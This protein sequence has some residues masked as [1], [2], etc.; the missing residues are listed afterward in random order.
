MF[1]PQ[2][3][4]YKTQYEQCNTTQYNTLTIPALL[5]GSQD[6]TVKARDSREI[7]AADMKFM[8]K[9]AGYTWTDY[10]TNTKLVKELNI[11]TILYKIQEYNRNWV[12]YVKS[13]VIDYL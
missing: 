11:T 10:K 7:T 6:C 3:T 4:L 5:Q 9:T 8:R 12:Q 13:I 2:K 1:R